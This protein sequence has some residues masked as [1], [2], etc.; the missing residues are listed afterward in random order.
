MGCPKGYR[1]PSEPGAVPGRKG[2][3]SAVA[4]LVVAIVGLAFGAADQFL[5][6][7]SITLGPWAATAAQV[8]APWLVL[9]FLAGMAQ[10]R[11]RR[12][13]ILGLLVS[14]SALLGYFA[15]TYSPIEIHPWTWHRFTTG[16]VAITTRGWY[17]PLYILGGVAT[18]PLFGLLG[19][20][21]RVR[22]WW[23][24][25]AF[26]AGAI[27][28]EPLARFGAGELMPP[29]PVWVVEVALGAVVAT[30]FTITVVLSRQGGVTRT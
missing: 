19:Q 27:C 30:L 10:V 12:A 6:S 20:R 18:G 13:A 25:A 3:R 5:G 23:V 1:K 2:Y 26:V 24:S 17:N 9:P 4:F 15:M 16:L 22:R 21:W 7:L 11:A 29:A 28:L 8:S 14:V